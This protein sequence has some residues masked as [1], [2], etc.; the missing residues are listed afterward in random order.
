MPITCQSETVY[1]KGQTCRSCD[2]HATAAYDLI[3]DDLS[4]RTIEQD[5]PGAVIS[6]TALEAPQKT[7]VRAERRP[8]G[9]G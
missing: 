3:A 7:C 1:A 5:G 9:Y 2:A 4:K 6:I 8:V